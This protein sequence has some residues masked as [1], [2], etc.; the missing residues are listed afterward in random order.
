MAI[1]MSQRVQSIIANAG[2]DVENLVA[3]KEMW[4]DEDTLHDWYEERRELMTQDA[5]R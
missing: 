4:F 5:A 2:Y 3:P 1:M